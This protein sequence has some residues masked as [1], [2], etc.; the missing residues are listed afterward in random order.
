MAPKVER[1]YG[2]GFLGGAVNLGWM[3]EVACGHKVRIW[4]KKEI[5]SG[6]SGNSSAKRP[7]KLLKHRKVVRK[8]LEDKKSVCY[9]V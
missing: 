2:N 6:N 8:F 9:N 4:H 5:N 1:L 7:N 3:H